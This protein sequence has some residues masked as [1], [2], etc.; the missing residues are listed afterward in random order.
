[1]TDHTALLSALK[2]NRANKSR[3]SRLIRWVDKLLH[4][5]FSIKHL[6]GKDMG[7]TDYLSRHP[8]QTPPPPISPDDELFVINRIKEFTFTLLNEERKHNISTNQNAPFGQTHKSH[9]VISNTQSE[10]NKANAFCHFSIHNQSH[11]FSLLNSSQNSTFNNQTLSRKNISNPNNI[12]NLSNSYHSKTF[13]LSN[14]QKISPYSN[15]QN[16]YS[17][18]RPKIN[19][20]TRNKPDFNTFDR[21]IIKRAR[22]PNKR[23]MLPTNPNTPSTSNTPISVPPKLI[24]SHH[25][26]TLDK[27][28]NQ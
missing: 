3:Q 16:Y 28:E 17:Q 20:V 15:P 2:P 11:S 9:D 12:E 25:P 18:P 13:N 24:K 27:A 10:Q 4:Y 6:P 26:L 19:V 23:T 22:R 21:Q 1:M 5:T 7:F 14:K 8:H